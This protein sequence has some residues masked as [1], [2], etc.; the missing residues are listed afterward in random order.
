MQIFEITQP[1]KKLNEISYA[2]TKDYVSAKT[3]DFVKNYA[4]ATPA[5]VSRGAA[6]GTGFASALGKAITNAPLKALG[7]KTGAD[8][9]PDPDEVGLFGK[10]RASIAARMDAATRAAMPA[11][12]QQ[13]AQQQK[14]WA[15]S[16]ADMMRKGGVAKMT[17]LD[18][19]QLREPLMKQIETMTK[20]YRLSNYKNLPNEVDPESFGGAGKEEA[21][22]T[23][24][25]ID[26]AIAAILSPD[27]KQQVG[28][29]ARNNWINLSKEIYAAG[30]QAQFREKSYA[31]G[32]QLAEPEAVEE[33]TQRL[34]AAGLTADKLRLPPNVVRPTNDSRVNGFLSALGLIPKAVAPAP[35]TVPAAAPEPAMAEAVGTGINVAALAQKAAS[36]KLTAQALNLPRNVV[37]LTNDP[38]INA[39]LQAVGLVPMQAGAR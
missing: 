9:V 39:L 20:P 5:A 29:Q 22:D 12:T 6:I 17:E 18:P 16:L 30:Q 10:D 1:R 26:A 31:T 2:A 13:A 33:L 34:D 27:P 37:A 21:M 36:A 25:A 15:A 3:P 7:A 8:L 4:A 14:M 35:K 38:N 32:G 24:E 19:A 11:I 28:A 23:V